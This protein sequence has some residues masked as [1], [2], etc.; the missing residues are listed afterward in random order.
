MI[1]NVFVP[2]IPVTQGSMRAFTIKGTNRAVVTHGK[3]KELNNWRGTIAMFVKKAM[4]DS[5]INEPVPREKPVHID[6][7]F[8][9]PR[10]KSHYGTGKN[11]DKIKPS[12]PIFHV[13]KPDG[14]KLFRALG[15]ALKGVLYNDDSQVMGSFGKGYSKNPG[16]EIT[17]TI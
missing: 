9:F 7:G 16:V 3:S 12:A 15:D 11:A 2:G 4:G 13:T 8:Y 10:P 6:A 17:I 5:G 1:I 14:D